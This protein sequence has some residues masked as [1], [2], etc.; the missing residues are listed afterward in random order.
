MANLA[1]KVIPMFDRV[2]LQR[3]KVQTKVGGII[4]PEAAAQKTNE[5]RVVAIGKGLRASDGKFT[6]PSVQVG[7]LVLLAEYR[8]DEIK[9]NNESY[10][11]VRE[12]DIL[13]KIEE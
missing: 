3:A 8:G 12:D 2:L 5:A 1:K 6:P 10:I 13:A 9:L 7:D 11:L 4:I